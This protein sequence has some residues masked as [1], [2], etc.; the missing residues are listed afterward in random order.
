MDSAPHNVGTPFEA[1]FAEFIR[2][3]L[4]YD[5]ET[6]IFTWRVNN[7][8]ARVGQQT[9]CPDTC[10][11]LIIRIG[12]TA[13]SASRLAW[14]ISHDHWP[15]HQIRHLN[16]DPADNRLS[17]L[18]D[19]THSEIRQAITKPQCN[20][21][22]GIIGVSHYSRDGTWRAEI[23]VEKEKRLLG[24]FHNKETARQVREAAKQKY[25]QVEEI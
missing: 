5:P 17:N 22:S 2:T 20:N 7:G 25:H 19:S 4:A 6:G 11:H 9:G 8:R 3:L 18:C 10:G 21:T 1:D 14:L 16:K 23:G 13:Y 15:T 24:Y 12:G